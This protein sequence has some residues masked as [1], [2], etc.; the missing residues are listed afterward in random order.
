MAGGGNI[1]YIAKLGV[2][3][4]TV[5]GLVYFD[6]NADGVRQQGDDGL[7]NVK[8][9]IKKG[10][11]HYIGMSRN[12]GNY[13]VYTLD[14]RAFTARTL[15]KKYCF[16]T[17]PLSR[18]VNFV[19]MDSLVCGYDFGIQSSSVKDLVVEVAPPHVHRAGREEGYYVS[20]RNEGT[21]MMSGVATMK[22]GGVQEFVSSNPV[23][24]GYSNSVLSW[25]YNNLLAG[26]VRN[27][28]AGL[29]IPTTVF[30]NTVLRGGES[31][32]NPVVGDETPQNN[33]K[34]D[35]GV[36]VG[37]YDPNA[38]VVSRTEIGVDE[39]PAFAGMTV[40]E[41]GNELC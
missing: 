23:Q 27:V 41:G 34:P 20:Y 32:C 37:P 36:L 1:S 28:F 33:V 4:E 21:E 3:K 7:E 15:S 5:R 38:K 13:E 22:H 31:V 24:N 29:K 16:G 2:A 35:T 19:S 14:T 30:S 25:N 40:W 12:D 9:E 10:S 17:L 26:E 8:V 6:R 39:I 11:F 18:G